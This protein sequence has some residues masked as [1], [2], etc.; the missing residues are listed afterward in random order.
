VRAQDGVLTQESEDRATWTYIARNED[1]EAVPLVIEHRLRPGWK[2][3]PGHTPVES[4]VDTERFRVVLEPKKETRLVVREV[5]VGDTRIAVGDITEAL[6]ADVAASGIPA[7]KLE[8]AL[9]PVLDKR[10]ELARADRQL[11]DLR[12][13]QQEI[14]TDQ[15]RL[16]EN[17]KALRGSAEEKQL[18]QRYTRQLDEQ[19]TRLEQ[20]KQETAKATTERN[21]IREELSRLIATISFDVSR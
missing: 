4:T 3:A 1:D 13:Q 11:E 18:L 16:R 5:R 9:R 19:E 2:L 20:I 6:I 14:V 21:R 10:A 17:M 12:R 7:T 15:N 8:R